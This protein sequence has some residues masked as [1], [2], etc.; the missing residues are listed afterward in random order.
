MKYKG[1]D[2]NKD[3]WK[4]KTEAEFLAHEAHHGLTEE[5]M[6]KAFSM[7]HPTHAIPAPEINEDLKP[8]TAKVD[9]EENKP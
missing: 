3:F 4:T 8:D 2:F 9:V 7:M 1:I 5:E 6:K